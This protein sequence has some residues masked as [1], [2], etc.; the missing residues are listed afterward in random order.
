MTNLRLSLKELIQRTENINI[1]GVTLTSPLYA[2]QILKSSDLIEKE[3]YLI[4]KPTRYHAN[5]FI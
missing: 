5:L 1:L 2:I 4:L 3:I